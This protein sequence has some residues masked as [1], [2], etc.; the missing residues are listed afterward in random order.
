M[1]PTLLSWEGEVKCGGLGAK[2]KN[3]IKVQT[4]KEAGD[5]DHYNNDNHDDKNTIWTQDWVQL[6]YCIWTCQ[7]QARK[8]WVFLQLTRHVLVAHKEVDQCHDHMHFALGDARR[9]R[10]QIA[11]GKGFHACLQVG[12]KITPTFALHVKP[13]PTPPQP[14][15]GWRNVERPYLRRITS[16]FLPHPNPKHM[17]QHRTSWA[18]HICKV[19]IVEPIVKH[20]PN[21][22]APRHRMPTPMMY[23]SSCA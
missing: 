21:V 17:T 5:D 16:M 22:T 7:R 10:L 3:Q 8:P 18:E 19:I 23:T 20:N 13:R 4:V 2:W 15:D 14:H 11:I 9:R 12:I 1:Y 6:G